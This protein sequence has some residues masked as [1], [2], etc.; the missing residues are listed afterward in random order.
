[1][2][3]RPSLFLSL[4][5]VLLTSFSTIVTKAQ[6]V[7]MGVEFGTLSAGG[8][9]VGKGICDNPN[10]TGSGTKVTFQLD[11]DRKSVV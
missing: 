3:F 10:Y 8:E 6:T 11:P 7:T 9:C 4:L 5:I 1:M 2:R